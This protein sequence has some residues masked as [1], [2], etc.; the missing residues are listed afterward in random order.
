MNPMYH[1]GDTDVCSIA[2]DLESHDFDTFIKEPEQFISKALRDRLKRSLMAN[3]QSGG[4]G[5]LHRSQGA[6]AV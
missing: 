5:T 2:I 6:Q 3:T 4:Q 1:K